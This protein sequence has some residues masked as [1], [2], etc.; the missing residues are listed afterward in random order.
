MEI[1]QALENALHDAMRSKNEIVLKTI[2]L[3][4]STVKLAEIEKGKT[5]D[6]AGVVAVLQKEIKSRKESIADAEKASRPDLVASANAEI[7]IL[8]AYLPKQISEEELNELVKSAISE[9]KASA[10]SDMGKVMKIVMPKVQGR[11]AGD[12][13][14]QAVRKQLGG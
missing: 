4:M 10:P 13:L 3:V 12:V 6:D 11:V 9:I 2:R 1:K 7:S 5:M 8:E 14:S